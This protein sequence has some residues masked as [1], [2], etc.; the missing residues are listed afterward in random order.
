VPSWSVVLVA[1]TSLHAAFQLTVS[2]LVYPA[3]VRVAAGAFARAHADHSRSIVPLVALVYSAALVGAGGAVCAAPTSVAAWLAALATG[4]ALL[5]T[6]LRAAPLHGR[7]G[8][9]GSEPDLLAALLRADRVRT[10]AAL[11]AVVAALV[12]ASSG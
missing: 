2:V 12:H 8:R 4:S 11:V 1:T 9:Q 10:A 5:A 3:L 6:A 7:L